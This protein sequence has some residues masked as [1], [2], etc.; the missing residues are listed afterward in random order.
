MPNIKILAGSV[1]PGRFNIQ[2]A[3]WIT[4]LAKSRSDMSAEL[5]DLQ[6]L[7][8]PFLDEAGTAKEYAYTKE[9]TKAWAKTIE[10]SDGFVFVTPE[11]NHSYSPVLKNALDFLYHEWGYKPVAFVSYGGIAGGTRAVEHL[12]GVAGELKMYDLR[13]QVVLPVYWEHTDGEGKYEFT[14]AHAAAATTMLDDLAFWA[15][16]MKTAREARASKK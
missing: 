12:R 2:P 15:A 6:T 5:I 8:L 3:T 9:H 10:E 11:Y 14:E 1:R 13:E 7:N 16:Q 4:E